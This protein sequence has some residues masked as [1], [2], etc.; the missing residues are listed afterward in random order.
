MLFFIKIMCYN[1]YRVGDIVKKKENKKN[2]ERSKVLYLL[3]V[4]V[5][6]VTA[7]VVPIKTQN[8]STYYFNVR[9]NEFSSKAEYGSTIVAKDTES[10]YP[11]Y[12]VVYINGE[13]YSIYVYNY[14]DTL[15][16]YQLEFDRLLD[17]IVDYNEKDKMIRYLHS[18]GTGTYDE[19]L[20]DLPLIVE[21]D[22]LKFY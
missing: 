22:N 17:G 18:K 6:F 19:L 20:N 7:F 16:Q 12:Y 21:C 15:S 8:D 9:D 10:F 5:V 3:I 2:K 13:D 14:Y 11:K 4:I 1:D